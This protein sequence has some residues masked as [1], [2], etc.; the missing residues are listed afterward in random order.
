MNVMLRYVYKAHAVYVSFTK[1]SFV[2]YTLLYN[3]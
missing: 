1:N 2:K 3:G